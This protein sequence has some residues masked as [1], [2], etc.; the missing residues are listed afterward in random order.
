MKEPFDSLN[1]IWYFFCKRPINNNG[2]KTIVEQDAVVAAAAA[3]N[4]PMQNS[5]VQTSEKQLSQL[6][7]IMIIHTTEFAPHRVQEKERQ[8]AMIHACTLSKLNAVSKAL[9]DGKIKAK[10]KINVQIGFFFL[11]ST[12]FVGK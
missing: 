1:L 12:V 11:S 4:L 3:L 5:V 8:R 9:L 2:F 10:Y 6:I 7:I